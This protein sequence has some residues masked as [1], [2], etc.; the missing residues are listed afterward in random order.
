MLARLPLAARA[1][2]RTVAALPH[3]VTRLM[4]LVLLIGLSACDSGI[5]PDE[6]DPAEGTTVAFTSNSLTLTENDSTATLEVQLSNPDGEP[7]SVDVLFAQGASTADATDLGLPPA[8]GLNG[9][10]LRTITFEADA[11]D[12][13]TQALRFSIADEDDAEP[14]ETAIFALQNLTTRGSATLGDNDVLR[15]EIGF[16]TI[17]EVREEFADG[18]QTF[19]V[20]GVVSRARGDFTYIQD[21]ADTEGEI[22][23]LTI[24][25]TGGGFAADV[26]SGAIAP[27]TRL[28]VTG[29][30]SYFA[31]LAQL[32]TD[33]LLDYQI[34]EQGA[35]PAPQ[36]VT[37]ADL[38]ANGESFEGE[39]VEV[40]GVVF[41]A[42]GAF[43]ASTNYG[44]DDGTGGDVEARVVGSGETELSGDPIPA[45]PVTLQT[46]VGQFNGFAGDFVDTG[47]QLLLID[48]D[49]IQDD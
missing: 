15:L 14:R 7:V 48:E 47:Y 37:L 35:P 3:V 49:D 19:T 20:Q 13:A 2:Q 46:V 27:G 5:A 28:Q 21:P 8:E 40:D 39:L 41:D 44:I 16:P 33:D 17:A 12:G 10:V 9:L 6:A 22:G 38:E 36:Q 1:A 34:L 18:E 24:R 42:S 11:E 23:G 25:Q 30:I 45:G 29:R 26:T 31:G 43:A 4:G 32:N